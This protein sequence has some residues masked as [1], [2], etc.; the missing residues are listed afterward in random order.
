MQDMKDTY[1]SEWALIVRHAEQLRRCLMHHARSMPCRS[2]ILVQR[3]L[4][5]GLGLVG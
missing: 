4:V 3:S 5:A 2:M 1:S